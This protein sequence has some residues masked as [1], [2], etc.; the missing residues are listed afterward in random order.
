V[1]LDAGAA[2]RAES[3]TPHGSNAGD[4]ANSP[5]R[6]CV[7]SS[8]ARDGSR[9]YAETRTVYREDESATSRFSE[10]DITSRLPDD[11]RERTNGRWS[12]T[13]AIFAGA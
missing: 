7:C 5:V 2:A 1:L 3:A 11:S 12:A 10:R 13:L 9:T 6:V 8:R 4:S